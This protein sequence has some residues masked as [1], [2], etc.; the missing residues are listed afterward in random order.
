[1]WEGGWGGLSRAPLFLDTERITNSH[2]HHHQQQQQLR[3]VGNKQR[4]NE[5]L[6]AHLEKDQKTCPTH[7]RVLCLVRRNSN[8]P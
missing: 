5:R 6:I 7:P 2:H 3:Q 8:R 1:M 4:D